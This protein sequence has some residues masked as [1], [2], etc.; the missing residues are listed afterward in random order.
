MVTQKKEW[1]EEP[2]SHPL[3]TKIPPLRRSSSLN[4]YRVDVAALF[5]AIDPQAYFTT[6]GDAAAK[7]KAM[8]R[9]LDEAA[10]NARKF[11]RALQEIKRTIDEVWLETSVDADQY[12]C[13]ATSPRKRTRTQFTPEELAEQQALEAEKSPPPS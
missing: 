3:I 9:A 2:T 11:L 6:T 4:W 13:R 7:T 8:I 1:R 12:Y 5:P 10:K